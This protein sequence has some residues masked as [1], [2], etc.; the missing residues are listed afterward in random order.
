MAG[1]SCCCSAVQPV[2]FHLSHFDDSKV[3]IHFVI[4]GA[5]EEVAVGCRAQKKKKTQYEA[6]TIM[7][8][9]STIPVLRFDFDSLDLIV[10]TYAVL[11]K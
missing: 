6:E 2:C 8:G 7:P 11:V 10:I 4:V 9:E 5:F 1:G 3:L